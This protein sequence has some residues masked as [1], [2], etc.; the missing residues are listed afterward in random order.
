MR[1][2]STRI[3]TFDV[4]VL[5]VLRPYFDRVWDECGVQLRPDVGVLNWDPVWVS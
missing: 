4:E 2:H 5:D 3:D 1:S